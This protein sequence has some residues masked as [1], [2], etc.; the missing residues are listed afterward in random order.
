LS[1][2]L[3]FAWKMAG[4]YLYGA[5]GFFKYFFE[6][7]FHYNFVGAYLAAVGLF[8]AFARC[9][10]KEGRVADAIR[11]AA[12]L[13][14]G[15]Y[16]L[17]M[18]IDIRDNW[19]PWTQLLFGGLQNLGFIGIILDLAVTVL[20]VFLI[21]LAVDSL[22]RAIFDVIEKKLVDEYYAKKGGKV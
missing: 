10:I 2:T 3:I 8:A 1:S 14:L 18:N 21:G 22:R 4:H 7:P 16:L 11:W 9:K 6:L 20:L 5:T 13:V 17:H 19:Y 15:V 12:P